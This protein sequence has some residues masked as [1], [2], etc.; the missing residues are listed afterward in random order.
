MLHIVDLNDNTDPNKE[1]LLLE[2]AP[3]IGISFPSTGEFAQ[4]DYV[5]NKVMIRQL[6][7][8]AL[9]LPEADE[10]QDEN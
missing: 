6:E 1:I 8:E 2:N 4:I 3:A 9:D 7:A 10:D 5:M